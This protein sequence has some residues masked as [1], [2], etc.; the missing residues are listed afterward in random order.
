MPKHEVVDHEEWVAR[1]KAF[2]EREKEFTKLRD[3]LSAARRAL[4]WEK[5]D[6]DY[7]FE[8]VGGRRSLSELFD[9]RP[10]LL[11]YH[12]MFG[13]DWDAGCPSCSFWADGYDRNAIHL[14]QR[15]ITLIAVS[16]APLEKI[17]A[18]RERMGWSFNWVSSL[19]NDFNWDY[20]VSFKQEDLDAGKVYY[21][22]TQT[23]F[24]SSEGPGLSAFYRDGDGAV[25]HTYSTFARGL[26]MFNAAYHMM[27]MAPLGRD[28]GEL[29]YAQAWVRRRDEY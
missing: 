23:P 21:N 25:F 10:Q 18:Y 13:P 6:R 8:T 11:V 19:E 12:F 4:P 1:R 17:Q 24:G 7:V 9:G 28:E 15:N 29:P 14:A 20:D 5:V 3:E 2:L 27:D 16:R 26:D 22:Y